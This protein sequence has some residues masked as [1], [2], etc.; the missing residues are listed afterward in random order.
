MKNMKNLIIFSFLVLSLTHSGIY[1]YQENSGD[2]SPQ[3]ANQTV[4]QLIATMAIV[5]AKTAELLSER[6][7]QRQKGVAN[8]IQKGAEAI[9]AVAEHLTA[10]QMGLMQI[11][12]HY[13][14]IINDYLASLQQSDSYLKLLDQILSGGSMK[15]PQ[16][17]ARAMA[18]TNWAIRVKSE[19][20]KMHG[21]LP[22]AGELISKL[23]PH[24]SKALA[25]A[26]EIL[27]SPDTH[28][29]VEQTMAEQIIADH[30]RAADVAKS[31][32]PLAEEENQENQEADEAAAQI[33]VN[34]DQP[35]EDSRN[36]QQPYVNVEPS[37]QIEG[38]SS[39]IDKMSNLAENLQQAAQGA[40]QIVD[41]L[42][43][44][45]PSSN[46]RLGVNTNYGG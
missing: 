33:V 20:S 41:E 44:Q 19:I 18:F 21:Y 12:P 36:G 26:E 45:P 8:V 28:S 5:S 25:E 16:L 9:D 23:N 24:D 43:Q 6:R 7:I 35:P 34:Q 30:Q 3:Q 4:Q 46:E 17:K 13:L 15:K 29:S 14:R 1:A 22:P 32:A 39:I 2:V 31:L 40:Q 11:K 10:L 38:D 37:D 42:T 27:S